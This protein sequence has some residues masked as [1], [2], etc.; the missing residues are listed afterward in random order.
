FTPPFNN[1]SSSSHQQYP[2]FALSPQPTF[3]AIVPTAAVYTP[4]MTSK[5]RS[6]TIA[7]SDD[8]PS[9]SSSP[10]RP[11]PTRTHSKRLQRRRT[12]RPTWVT[13]HHSSISLRNVLVDTGIGDILWPQTA[14]VG[15]GSGC[16]VLCF[17]GSTDAHL[18]ALASVSDL[19]S[20]SFNTPIHAISLHAPPSTSPTTIPIIDRKSTRLNSSHV[21]IS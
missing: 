11:G 1:P 21:K 19:L 12:D 18:T 20:K 10:Q 8:P 6:P 7:F 4:P 2:V 14:T 5:K 13:D 3:T 9:A 15:K 16:R 17:L